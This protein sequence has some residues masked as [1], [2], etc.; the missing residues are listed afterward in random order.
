MKTPGDEK[1][2][3]GYADVGRSGLGNMLFPWARCVLWTRDHAVGM[4]APEWWTFRIGPYFRRERDKRQ[5]QKLL[6]TAGYIG[7][8]RKQWLMRALRRV[9]EDAL[10]GAPKDGVVVQFKGIKGYFEPLRGRAD[11]VRSELLRIARRPPAASIGSPYIGVHVRRGDFSI[12]QSAKTLVD[13]A[14]CYQIAIEW[15]IEALRA[16]R[17]AIGTPVQALVFSDGSPAELGAL[18]A[19]PNVALRAGATALDDMLA[20]GDSGVLI[21]SGSTFSMWGSYLR[22]APTLWYPG[23]RRQRVLGP[24]NAPIDLEPEW[25]GGTLSTEFAA[26]AAHA[27]GDQRAKGALI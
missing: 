1:R 27:L 23:Q 9:D 15:Y 10:Q 8:F 19:E 2:I 7:G 4:L 16:V 18:L 25:G 17:S 5:Y 3:Y 20:L 22:G 11:E 21:A 13:G 14:E 12:P 26:A 6:G 24:T